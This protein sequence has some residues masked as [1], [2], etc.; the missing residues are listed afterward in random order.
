MGTSLSKKDPAKEAYSIAVQPYL[1]PTGLYPT[2][3]WDLKVIKRL[4][5][6]RKVAPLFGGKEESTLNPEIDVDF[7]ECPIC[8]LY[9]PGGLNRTSCCKKGICTE[10]YFQIRKPNSPASCPFCNK[11]DFAV[12]FTGPL[13]TEEKEKEAQEQQRVLDLRIKMRNEELQE[14]MNRENERK[15]RLSMPAQPSQNDETDS[16]LMLSTSLPVDFNRNNRGMES[17]ASS[18]Q[19]GSISSK[20]LDSSRAISPERNSSNQANLSE[21]DLDLDELML[22]E[23]IRLSLVKSLD[24]HQG[25][26]TTNE[27]RNEN[28]QNNNST[29]TNTTNANTFHR[30]LDATSER[31][32]EEKK[33]EGSI[34]ET[35][36]NTIVPNRSSHSNSEEEEG[37][38][39]EDLALALALS[40]SR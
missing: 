4:V 21:A 33:E 34:A 39:D 16:S 23:A 12:A 18:F 15:S 22:N 9:Y 30:S 35:H 19:E 40:M 10:C 8:F 13:S 31:K 38:D 32:E 6:T 17:E 37:T 14:D 1:V 28:N 2:C 29:T 26:P 7:E 5:L 11:T 36:L 27:N 3:A 20:E 24:S 25:M